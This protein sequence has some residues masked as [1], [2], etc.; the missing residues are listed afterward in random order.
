[1]NILLSYTSH[2]ASTA[3]YMEAALR[4]HH[5]VVTFGPSVS[6]DSFETDVIKA[7]DL[8]SIRAQDKGP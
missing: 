6:D 5:D 8:E 1:M 3:A 2:P 7:W 4:K